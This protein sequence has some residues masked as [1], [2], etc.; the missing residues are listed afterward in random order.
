MAV[1]DG[2]VETIQKSLHVHGLGEQ[3]RRALTRNTPP[4]ATALNGHLF[5]HVEHRVNEARMGRRAAA[6]LSGESKIKV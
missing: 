5:F 4:S 6:D 2:Y 1:S 3:I